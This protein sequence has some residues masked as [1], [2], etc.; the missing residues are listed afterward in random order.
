MS[1]CSPGTV[2]TRDRLQFGQ[3]NEAQGDRDQRVRPRL[4]RPARLGRPRARSGSSGV[5]ARS[6]SATRSA[7]PRTAAEHHHFAPPTLET[8]VVPE[9]PAD[10][11]A[12]HVA[13]AQLA[14]QDPL[15]NLRQDDIAPGALR[16]ALRRGAEGGHP[17]DAGDRLRHRRRFPRDDDDLHRTAGR[18]RARPSRCSATRPIRSSPTVGL[19]IEPAAVGTGVEFRLEVELGAMPRV[20]PHGSRGHRARDAAAG[21]LRVGGDRLHGHD[22]A[23]RLRAAAEPRPPGFRQVACRALAGD[24][25]HLTPL[26]L[27]SALQQAGTS[28]CEPIHRFHLEI[29]ADTLGPILPALAGCGA[30]PADTGDAGFVVH[31]RGRDSGSAG[32]RAAATAAGADSRRGRAGMRLRPLRTGQRHDS[33]PARSDHNPLNREEYLLRVAR[34]VQEPG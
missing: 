8:V 14:E 27:M 30:R 21:D 17:G 29:P 12:L 19:R 32:A 26:V 1:A 10:R 31:A 2:R 28:V 34:R 11:G 22:D 23:L 25:R 13:L 5:S 4:G 7:A 15:I 20:V 16:L 33:D 24:F 3:D 18:H 9:R 6:R